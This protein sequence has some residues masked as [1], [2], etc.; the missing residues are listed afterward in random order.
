MQ[1]PAWFARADSARRA[2]AGR[3][4]TDNGRDDWGGPGG[5]ATAAATQDNPPC[6]L[7]VLPL[8]P[9]PGAG[10]AGAAAAAAAKSAPPNF[11][12]PAC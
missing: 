10:A 3:R 8:P 9:P 6:E 12:F 5:T 1:L 11:G 7:N 4:F 2:A